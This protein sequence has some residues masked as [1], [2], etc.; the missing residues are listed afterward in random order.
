M[1][2]DYWKDVVCIELGD[3]IKDE[4]TINSK[5]IKDLFEFGLNV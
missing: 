5:V 4:T 3:V 1:D 2:E